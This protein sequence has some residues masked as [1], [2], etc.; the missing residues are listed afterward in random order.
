MT[1]LIHIQ[2]C[3]YFFYLRY[4]LVRG[5]MAIMAFCS[6]SR[7]AEMIECTFSQVT[8]DQ[9]DRGIWFKKIHAKNRKGI[10]TNF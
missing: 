10:C 4:L 5:A 3:K 7:P 6:S 9:S 8:R 2:F 1:Y